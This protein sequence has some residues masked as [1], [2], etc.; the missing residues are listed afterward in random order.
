LLFQNLNVIII[1]AINLGAFLLSDNILIAIMQS[2]LMPNVS[3]MSVIMQSN[4]MPSIIT[5]SAILVK[6]GPIQLLE[7]TTHAI[8]ASSFT[9]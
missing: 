6:H 9:N 7:L 3:V 1:S 4:R 2:F 5:M 8:A